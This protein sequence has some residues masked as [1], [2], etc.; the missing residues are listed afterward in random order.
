VAQK[1]APAAP[2]YNEAKA[3]PAPVYKPGTTGADG[4]IDTHWGSAPERA[5]S[6][7]SSLGQYND[8]LLANARE[9]ARDNQ[10]Q[11][12]SYLQQVA[13]VVPEAPNTENGYD[14]V[15]KYLK[16]AKKVYA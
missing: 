5:L 1:P 14:E 16:D 6:F 15:L 13:Q 8:S 12:G 11:T 10:T 3:A 2:V 9:S 4:F 7:A